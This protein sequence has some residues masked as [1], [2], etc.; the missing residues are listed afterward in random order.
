MLKTVTISIGAIMLLAGS[1]AAAQTNAPAV[2]GQAAL[3]VDTVSRE[4]QPGLAQRETQLSTT[5]T[6]RTTDRDRSAAEAGIDVRQVHWVGGRR[7]DRLSIYDA[8]V[9]GRIGGTTAVRVRAGHLWIND[10]G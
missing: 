9:G 10:L 1:N 5:L 2:T 6:L 4:S 7:P 3:H 8:F